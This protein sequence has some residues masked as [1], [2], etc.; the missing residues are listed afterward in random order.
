ML[1]IFKSVEEEEGEEEEAGESPVMFP[2]VDGG[3]LFKREGLGLFACPPIGYPR[4]PL[5]AGI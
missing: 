3:Y 4:G 5:P 2:V 1:Y